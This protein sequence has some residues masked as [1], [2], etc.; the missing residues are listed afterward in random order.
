MKIRIV[1]LSLLA[2]SL[3]LP[4]YAADVFVAPGDP[5]PGNVEGTVTLLPGQHT[6]ATT[7]E[8]T[9]S[10]TLTAQPGAVWTSTADPAI[11]VHANDVT[12]SNLNLIS[13]NPT[14][15]AIV[16][17]SPVTLVQPSHRVSVISCKIE[18]FVSGILNVYGDWFVARDNEVTGTGALLDPLFS[19]TVGILNTMGSNAVIEKNKVSGFLDGIFVSG[20]HGR[21]SNNRITNSNGSIIF[22]NWVLPAAGEPNYYGGLIPNNA[23]NYWNVH[24]NEISDGVFVP[25]Y[26]GIPSPVI[27]IQAMDGA[28]HN[29][30]SNNRISGVQVDIGLYGS[31]TPFSAL[32][33]PIPKTH[34]N[35]V[36]PGPEEVTINWG[37]DPDPT[38]GN[39]IVGSGPMDAQERALYNDVRLNAG[40][41]KV[42]PAPPAQSVRA[43]SAKWGDIKT[44]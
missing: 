21:A 9:K 43:L 13:A 34:E 23:A 19:D 36:V 2:I 28:N 18:G 32:T 42:K 41:P 15:T 38:Y 22:C 25:D 12:I 30:I 16:S 29:M 33:G 4:I 10:M 37:D 11:A 3:A 44:Q 35:V 17:G 20:S 31:L 27:G 6:T 5:I 14:A 1:L 39:V 7:V 40:P 24:S 8:V 26:F